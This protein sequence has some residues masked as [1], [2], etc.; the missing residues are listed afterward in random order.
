[1]TYCLT[2]SSYRDTE[3]TY[4]AIVEGKPSTLHRCADHATEV[5]A[6]N[7]PSLTWGG[8]HLQVG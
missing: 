4:T 1:M 7:P 8:R 5:R 3:P 6:S 2:Q